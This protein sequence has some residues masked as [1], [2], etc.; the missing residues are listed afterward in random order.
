[1]YSTYA[2]AKRKT[3]KVQVCRDSNPDLSAKRVS[4]ESIVRGLLLLLFL[5]FFI[6]VIFNSFSSKLKLLMTTFLSKE[7][8]YA[9]PVWRV[10]LARPFLFRP[11]LAYGLFCWII[12]KRLLIGAH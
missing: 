8:E 2:V 9:G 3:E 11:H 10:S 4:Q 12:N 1:M 7:N 5:F 6:I